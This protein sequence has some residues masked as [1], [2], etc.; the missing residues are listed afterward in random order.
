MR[1][2]LHWLFAA[3][4]YAA[5]VAAAIAIRKPWLAD[6]VWAVAILAMGY[7]IIVSTISNALRR[8][9]AVGFV[10]F[11]TANLIAW[12]FFTSRTPVMIGFRAAGYSVSREGEVNERN[13]TGRGLRDAF[14]TNSIRVVNG[15]GV[16]AAGFVGCL[17]G[18]IAYVRA[19]SRQI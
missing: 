15:V 12:V 6:V 2:S 3:T 16:L 1:F 11:A 4:T 7:A 8:A 17:V 18:R 5:L 10:V 13:P 14:D 19:E 9:I